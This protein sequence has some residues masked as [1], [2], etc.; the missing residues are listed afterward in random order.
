[1]A[2]LQ[3][4]FALLQA[5]DLAVV[6][7]VA[8]ELAWMALCTRGLATFIATTSRD[9]LPTTGILDVCSCSVV[10]AS[11]RQVVVDT[12]T[13]FKHINDLSPCTVCL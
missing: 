9:V 11:D 4:L 7:L 5:F 2:T 12:L 6:E 10:T 8:S 3:D 1:M 13:A